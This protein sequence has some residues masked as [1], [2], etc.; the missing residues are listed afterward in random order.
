[1]KN[2]RFAYVTYVFIIF[3]CCLYGRTERNPVDYVRPD[4]GGISILLTTTRPIVDLPHGYPQVTPQLNPGITDSYLATKIYGFPVVGGGFGFDGGVSLMPTAGSIKT[5]PNDIASSF[6]RDFETRTPYYYQGL[7]E[8]HN[9]EASY[10][11]GHF[12]IFYRFKFPSAGKRYINIMMGSQGS[13]RMVSP[14]VLEGSTVVYHVPSYFYLEFS[15]PAVDQSSWRFGGKPGEL[16][17]LEGN[18]I[19]LTLAFA[20]SKS[21]LVQAKVGLSFISLSQAQ[22]NLNEAIKGW[23]FDLRKQKTES[24]W[25]NLLGE[26]VVEGGTEKQKIIFY[27]SLYRAEEGMMDITEDGRYYSGFDRKVHNAHGNKFYTHDQLWDTFRCEHPLQLLL[28]PAQQE[29]MIRSL[30]RMDK[31]W[32]WLPSFPQLSG[33]FPAMIGDHADELI[34]DTYFKGYR[35]FDVEQAYQ[36]MKHEALDGTML[37]WR[38]GPMTDLGKVYL[39]KGFFPALREGEKETNP[40]VHPFEK[41]Q[42]VS[43]TLEAAYDDWCIAKMAKALGH[44]ADYHRF[45]KMAENYRN[46]F[47]KSIGFMAPK[48]AD[49]DWVKGFNP[50]LPSGQGGRDYFAEMNAWVW[51]FNVPHDAAGLIQLFGGRKPFLNKLDQLFVEQY[52]GVSKYV[53]LAKFPDMTGLIG[54]YA[55]GNEPSFDVAYLYDFAG[56]PWKTQKM[57]REIMEVWYNDTPLGVP[58]DDDLGAMGAWY[59]FSA[60]GFYPFCPGDP[61]YVIGSPLFQKTL[62]HLSNG[63]TFTIKAD[64]SSTQNKYIQS[65]TLNS[66][67][68]TRPWFTQ[69]DIARGGMLELEMGPRPNK[70]WGSAAEDVPPSMSTHGK[71]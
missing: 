17:V 28:N 29:Q 4:I 51:T 60:M 69:Q 67:P 26:I 9:I 6:D 64:D 7:L 71:H 53:F 1:M 19:G 22:K 40:E 12:A 23:N 66:K 14:T 45:L 50:I 34:A 16:R 8:D 47:D 63:R 37:P 15:T 68:L 10:T 48:S 44:T 57:L 41:R 52:D 62:I 33:E 42:A 46:V 3:A 2:L 18:K 61:Y 30:V 25:N 38:R 58:G 35:D 55:Q 65:A 36:A 11:V 5:D 32:G 27:S 56:E 20:G 31:Q 59:V 70:S 39:E 54:N 24:A 49:G 43:V 13:M 21:E